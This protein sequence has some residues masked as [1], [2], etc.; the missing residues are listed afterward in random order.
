M[1]KKPFT[2]IPQLLTFC[3]FS[4]PLSSFCS[5]LQ[6]IPTYSLF[7]PIYVL[8]A[9]IVTPHACT[10]RHM[11]PENKDLLFHNRNIIIEFGEFNIN[12]ILLSNII[13]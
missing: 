9:D 2:Y 13:I 5:P 8:V 10:L 6:S 12:I 1:S 7:W 11:S 3:H 4:L